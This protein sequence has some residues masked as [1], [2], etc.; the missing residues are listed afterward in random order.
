MSRVAGIRKGEDSSTDIP[1]SVVTEAIS[2]IPWIPMSEPEASINPASSVAR[3]P[4]RHRAYPDRTARS[5]HTGI[6]GVRQPA[7]ARAGPV[8]LAGR[9]P[10]LPGQPPCPG[11]RVTAPCPM[12]GRRYRSP[13]NTRQA[14]TGPVRATRHMSR[15][16][17]CGR[18]P[19]EYE[20]PLSFT[21]AA[22]PH[23]WAGL[24]R[25]LPNHRHEPS[26]SDIEKFPE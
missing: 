8:L 13:G 11:P 14:V 24:V 15:H 25:S 18:V 4:P 10:L 1:N 2:I 17:S 5:A 23:V 9:C 19:H 6:C 20:T 12:T 3:R 22:R 16:P 26:S 7:V 21:A